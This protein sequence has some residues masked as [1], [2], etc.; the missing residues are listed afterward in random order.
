MAQDRASWQVKDADILTELIALT[1]LTDEEAALLGGLQSHAREAAPALQDA[2]YGR[3]FS[4]S[5]TAE[6]LA[7]VP[8]ERLHS[9]AASWFA[10]IFGGVYDIGYAQKRL[11]IGEIHVRIGLPVRYPLAMLDVIMPFGEAIARKSAQPER[12]VAA[13]RKILALDIAIFNQAYEDNQLRHLADLVGG[14]RLARL[15]LTRGA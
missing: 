13:F 5:N 4:H 2:F 3:L 14:E 7:G 11:K 1:A 8:I 12:A 6:Y 10:D 9:M 15:L